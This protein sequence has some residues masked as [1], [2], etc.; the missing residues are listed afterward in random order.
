MA[1]AV[2]DVLN[3]LFGSS[4]TS[5]DEENLSSVIAD[6]FLNDDVDNSD[7]RYR[8]QNTRYFDTRTYRN[9]IELFSGIENFDCEYNHTPLTTNNC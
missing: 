6:Y 7:G 1:F 9:G 2:A 4:L 3:E 5:R 8:Y